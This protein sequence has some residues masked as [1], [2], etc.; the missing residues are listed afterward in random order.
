MQGLRPQTTGTGGLHYPLVPGRFL[1]F[2][3]RAAS[4]TGLVCSS[5]MKSTAPI[6]RGFSGN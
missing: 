4:R 2:C 6:S 3:K 5:S 1:E